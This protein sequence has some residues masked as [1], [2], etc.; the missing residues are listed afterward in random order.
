MRRLLILSHD[1][2]G[3]RMA[4]PGIRYWELARA[5]AGELRVTLAAPAPIDLAPAGFACAHYAPGDAAS[6]AALTASADVVL[7]NGYLLLRHPELALVAAPLLLDLYDPTL[8]ENLELFRERPAAERAAQLD[9]DLGLL[10]AQLAAGDAFICATERQ[11]DL[12]VGA[13]MA[14]GRISPELAEADPLLRRL[15]DVVSFGL[16]AEPAQWRAPALRGLLPGVGPDSPLA[17]WT[18]GLWDW[19]DPQTLIRAMPAVGAAIPGA[20]LVFLAGRHPGPA[21]PMRAPAAARALADELGLLGASV[22]FYDDWVPYAR[23]ADFLL[24]AD[25]LV[26]LHRPGLES[27]YAAVRSRFLDHLWAGR[28]S[29]VGAGDAAAALVERHG[30]GLAVPPQ[31]VA[32]TSAALIA[33][34]GDADERAACARRAWDLAEEYAWGRVAGPIRRFCAAPARTRPAPEPSASSVPAEPPPPPRED[35]MDDQSR[36]DRIGRLD[37][38][39]K[40]QPQPLSSGAPLLGQAKELANSLTRWY[41]QAIVDQQNSFNAAVVQSLQALAAN[42]D[43]RHTELTVHIH[44][45][46]NHLNQTRQTMAAMQRRADQ[47]AQRA[48]GLA[49]QIEGLAR[50]LSDVDDAETALAAAVAELRELAA[51]ARPD[52]EGA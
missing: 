52:Q 43:R 23:R 41:V 24:E 15:I 31:D 1:T 29:L 38:L 5:L 50:H 17:L 10:R 39:W 32:A 20:R 51:A 40:L 27:A 37:G 22:H 21:A 19:M 44:S 33:L 34:L 11:R 48:E 4:G 12:Y 46:H 47:L 45:L 49:Q 8:L 16:P 2:V 28:A 36:N 9:Q 26:S 3:G 13:L 25:L 30:L 6:L 35:S 18:G 42:D 14:Q 7:A